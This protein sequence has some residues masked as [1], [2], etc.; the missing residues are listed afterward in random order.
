M[1]EVLVHLHPDFAEELDNHLV[2]WNRVQDRLTFRGIRPPLEIEAQLLSPGAIPLRDTL[3]L[4]DAIGVSESVTSD[5]EVIVFTEKRIYEEPYYQLFFGG[6]G[7]RTTISLDFTRHL[8][9]KADN[10]KSYIFRAI[11]INIHS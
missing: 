3:R 7:Y 10:K 11:L 2:K 8:F 5:V 9:E 6:S 4:A 1:S